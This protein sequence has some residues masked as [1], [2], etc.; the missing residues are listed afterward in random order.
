MQEIYKNQKQGINDDEIDLRE[1]FHILFQGKWIIFSVTTFMSIAAVIYSLSLPNIY[2]SKAL[3]V[4]VDSSN[5]ISA[6]LKGY[7]GLAG[8]AG[9]S[10]PSGSKDSNS[11]KAIKKLTTLSFFKNNVLPN[12]LL[13]DLMSVEAWNKKTNVLSYDAN[14][15]N[16]TTNEWI[17]DSK[18]RRPTV[19][20]S[21]AVFK[22]EHLTVTQDKQTDFVTIAIKHESPFIAQKWT[23][24]LIEE[25]NAFYRQK[26]KLESQKAVIYLNTQIGKTNLSEIKQVIAELLQQETQK[27]TLIEAN[28]A[29][30][31]D[32]IDPPAVMEQ[33]SEPSRSLICIIGF[34][35]GG[36]FG[37]L[38]VLM[39]HYI[40]GRAELLR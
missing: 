13:P 23:E 5:S 4:P 11:A 17:E 33:K 1:L 6:S 36:I 21:F 19:Q 7:S 29:Y 39:K 25:I 8:M 35:F 18:K 24:L 9:I 30:V 37:I 26:D 27:L 32:Y 40:Y 38:L 10:L 16:N 14:I 28:K 3:L 31:F 15:Y 22:R 12:I 20:K 2:E 34:F